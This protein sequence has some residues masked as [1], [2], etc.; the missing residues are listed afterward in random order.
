MDDAIM[1]SVTDIIITLIVALLYL[2]I[3]PFQLAIFPMK[4]Y[5]VKDVIYSGNPRKA[6]GALAS[7][8]LFIFFI[9]FI[10]WIF[11]KR[12]NTAIW[13]IT[14]GSCLCS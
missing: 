2:L 5:S 10:L 7:R 13:G 3:I 9:F 14:M 4:Y 8:F 1:V 6:T 12:N 11:S